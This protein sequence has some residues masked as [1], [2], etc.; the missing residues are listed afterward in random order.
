VTVE[1]LLTRALHSTDEYEPSVDLFAKVQ[2]SIEED[3]AY[4]RRRRRVAV[5]ITIGLTV[6][7][8]WVVAFLDI[9]DG[10]AV[11]PWWTVEVLTLAILVAIVA[12]F[13]PLIRRF[14]LGLTDEIFRSHRATSWR[15]LAVLDIAYYLIFTAYVLMSTNVAAQREWGGGLARQLESEVERIAGMLMVMGLL[16]AVTIAV[17]P[18]VGLVFSSNWRRA[19]RAALGADA[20]EPAPQAE[21]AERV[22][23]VI[24]WGI[25]GLAAWFALGFLVGPGIFG[26]IL[27]AD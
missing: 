24:V 5:A 27:G 16:H 12:V 9:R 10:V 11:M 21:Q 25:A 2:R 4:R 8:A 14:G 3:V 1:E 17:L 22:V 7:L 15:F 20:P 19:V 26:L 6:A 23:K 13:G 18:V